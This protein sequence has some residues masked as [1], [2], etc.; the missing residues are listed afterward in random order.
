VANIAFSVCAAVAALSV[1]VLSA[2][3]GAAVVAIVFALLAIGFVLRAR[4]GHKR[5]S[6]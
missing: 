3:K 1:S 2:V 4:E 6:R 5:G